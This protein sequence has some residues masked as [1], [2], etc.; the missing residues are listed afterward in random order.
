MFALLVDNSL[1]L[2]LAHFLKTLNLK[3]R[4]L[5]GSLVVVTNLVDQA[6]CNDSFLVREVYRVTRISASYVS[7]LYD[8][9]R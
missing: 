9:E 6:A 2:G 8:V 5:D 4:V 7:L 1:P 3:T